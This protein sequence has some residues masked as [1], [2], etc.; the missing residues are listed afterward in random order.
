MFIDFILCFQI[1]RELRG[2]S[3][4]VVKQ[5]IQGTISIMV[6]QG[7][8]ATQSFLESLGIF[9]YQ[10]WN[11]H[12]TCYCVGHYNY[13]YSG[14]SEHCIVGEFGGK[15]VWQSGKMKK[16]WWTFRSAKGLLIV[17]TTKLD[18]VNLW[19]FAKFAIPPAKLACN[20]IMDTGKSPMV[21]VN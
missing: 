17:T 15:N 7:D 12:K 4:Q 14:T 19:W 3:W 5:I 6:C 10:L 21:T 11:N 16:F 18:G 1:W 2:W 9:A 8:V 20:T 13:M